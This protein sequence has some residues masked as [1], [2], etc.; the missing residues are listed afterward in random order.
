MTNLVGERYTTLLSL[1]HRQVMGSTLVV[2]NTDK[3]AAWV[4]YER[5]EYWW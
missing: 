3:Q 5:N 2:W 1:I 4:L